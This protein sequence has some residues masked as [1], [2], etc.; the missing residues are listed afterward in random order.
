MKYQD[1]DTREAGNQS[2]PVRVRGLKYVIKMLFS[3]LKITSHPVRVRGLK[4]QDAGHD[5]L[6]S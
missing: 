2:H 6:S 1:P 4:L 3:H 5:I